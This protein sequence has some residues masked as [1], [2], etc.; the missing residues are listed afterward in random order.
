MKLESLFYMKLNFKK[1]RLVLS[2]VPLH[3][4]GWV[5]PNPGFVGFR[6]TQS[7]LHVTGIIAK[8]E[9]QQQPISESNHEVSLLIKLAVFW[10]E[11]ALIRYSTA[12]FG[13]NYLFFLIL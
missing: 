5:E 12:K 9:T 10:P 1:L 11:A 3:F 7:N 6:C 8:C 13:G 2:C 4:V